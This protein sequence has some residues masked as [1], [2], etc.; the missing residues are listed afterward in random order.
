MTLGW[1]R[2]AGGDNGW[3]QAYNGC[4]RGTNPGQFV[5]QQAASFLPSCRTRMPF[6]RALF[7]IAELL[8]GFGGGR[9]LA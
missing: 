8:N 2:R 3:L 6:S 5:S 9:H 7:D 4:P 1:G